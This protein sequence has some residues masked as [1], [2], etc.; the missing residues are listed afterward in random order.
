MTTPC[1]N[2]EGMAKHQHD[3]SNLPGKDREGW[4]HK[5]VWSHVCRCGHMYAGVVTCMRS[6]GQRVK[7]IDSRIKAIFQCNQHLPMISCQEFA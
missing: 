3:L 4:Q 6:V 1:H 5:A 7:K 2:R